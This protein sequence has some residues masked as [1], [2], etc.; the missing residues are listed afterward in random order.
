MHAPS[1]GSLSSSDALLGPSLNE[2]DRH[3]APTIPIPLQPSVFG[4]DVR[5]APL[6][7]QLYP[8]SK[9]NAYLSEQLRPTGLDPSL[10]TPASFRKE[11]LQ[12]KQLLKEIALLRPSDAR[13]LG[14]LSRLLD[15]HDALCRLA[16][17]Y[18]SSLLQG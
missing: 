7:D 9:I 18:A 2:V 5:Q 10:L 8:P 16:H 14:R 11:L 3:Q 17:L 13:R 12:G 1:I 6:L 15:D 4:T